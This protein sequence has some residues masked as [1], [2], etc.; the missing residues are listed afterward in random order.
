MN[1]FHIMNLD[2]F[3]CKSQLRPPFDGYEHGDLLKSSWRKMGSNFPHRQGH[4]SLPPSAPSQLV[5]P[6]AATKMSSSK[7]GLRLQG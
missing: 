1:F 6:L 7:K 4:P 5:K 2:D 3:L